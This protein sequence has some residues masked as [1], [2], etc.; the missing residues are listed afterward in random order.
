M[1]KINLLIIGIVAM[2]GFMVSVNAAN[3]VSMKCEKTQIKIGESSNCVVYV[4]SNA[5][6]SEAKITLSASEHLGIKYLGV[7]GSTVKPNSAAGWSLYNISGDEYTFKNSIGSTG[8]SE[9]FAFNVTL[10]DSAKNLSETDDCGQLCIKAASFDGNV[11]GPLVDGSGTCF[12]PV[13]IEESCV[14]EDCNPKTGDF[15]NY[16]VIGVVGVFAIAAIV[17][18]RKSAKFYRV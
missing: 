16:V 2:F 4:E 3:G 8:K 9:L 15:M 1:K 18:A 10:L 7:V 12:Q 13:I 11:I 5:A 17:I 6:I 14:G